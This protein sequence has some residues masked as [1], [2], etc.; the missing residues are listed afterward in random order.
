[1][2]SAEGFVEAHKQGMSPMEALHSLPDYEL[3]YIRK[4]PVEIHRAALQ[5]DWQVFPV[6]SS[7]FLIGRRA[8][9]FE[10]TDNQQQVRSSMDP[11]PNWVLVTGQNSG[12]FVLEVDGDEGMASLHDLCGDDWNWLETLCSVTGEKRYIFFAWPEGRR[13]ISRNRQI[14]KGLRYLG[15]GDWVLLPPSRGPHGA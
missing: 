4:V 2:K 15:E 8:N 1:M 7:R 11:W 12:V 14:A 3:R 6:S 5:C 10:A 9:L 13:Q